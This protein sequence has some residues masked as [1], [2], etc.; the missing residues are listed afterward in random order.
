MAVAWRNTYERYGVVAKS[1]H[2]AVA[3]L[4]PL[5][6]ASAVLML[7]VDRDERVLGLTQGLLYDGHKSLGLVLLALA[8]AR[9]L[10]RWAAG[11]PHWAP[12]LAP[13]ERRLAHGVERALY[14]CLFLMPLSGLL[15]VMAG[16]YGVRLLGL[17]EL[18]RVLPVLP[19]LAWAGE[20]AHSLTAYALVAALTLHLGLVAKHERVDRDGLLTRMLPGRR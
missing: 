12:G 7:S 1:L 2:W 9:S 5:Q 11:L 14:L 10:W 18:P 13:W 8:L 3:V 16:G 19:A 20:V 6:F 4:I 15:H 17:W